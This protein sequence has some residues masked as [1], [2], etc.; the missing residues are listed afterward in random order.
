MRTF[1]RNFEIVVEDGTHDDFRC[2]V[3]SE[4]PPTP[5]MEIIPE[6]ILQNSLKVANEAAQDLK[7][8]IRKALSKFD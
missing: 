3:S 1:E 7:S 2:F 6:S 8:N 5:M 4:P